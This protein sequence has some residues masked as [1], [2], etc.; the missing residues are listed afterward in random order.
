MSLSNRVKKILFWEQ[1]EQNHSNVF[2]VC[3]GKYRPEAIGDQICNFYSVASKGMNLSEKNTDLRTTLGDCQICQPSV[4]VLK[5]SET[6]PL[7]FT[8]LKTLAI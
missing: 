2:C 4:Q 7:F 6:L 1:S 5:L 3:P 8:I